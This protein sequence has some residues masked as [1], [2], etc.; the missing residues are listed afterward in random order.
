[1][2]I[3]SVQFKSTLGFAVC[4]FCLLLLVSG[5]RHA[6]PKMFDPAQVA[7]SASYAPL[8]ENQFYPSLIM[9]VA[10]LSDPAYALADSSA[11][12][13]VSVT[14]PVSNAVLRVT[15][16]SSKLN[17]VTIFQ[18]VLPVKDMRYTF[19]P[20][21]KWKF[22][23]LYRTRQQGVADL[24]FTCYINDEEVDVKNLRINYRSAND[25]L[26]S[27]RDSAGHGHDYRWLFAAYVNE[28]HPYI[29]SI[30][31]DIMQQGVVTKISGYQSDAKS[32]V[33]QAEAIWYYALERGI[34]Y[35]SISCTSTPTTRSN[36]QHI[37][38]FDEV[39]N[40]RQANCVDA[41]VFF[42]SIM[43]KIGLKPVIFVEPCHA[44][45]GFYTDKGRKNLRLL[46]TTI[47][48]WADFPALTRDYNAVMEA[49]P[50]AKGKARISAAMY[51][52]YGKYLT[53]N[54]KKNWEE[55]KTDFDSFKRAVAHNLFLKAMEY[56]QD[57]Y[58]NNKKLFADPDNT[59]YQ[60]LDIEQLRKIVQ[61]I[62]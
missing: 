44:Y 3:R 49:N 2:S 21:V 56:D 60:Q 52:K 20:T 8:F 4:G 13:S 35:S 32:V 54:E 10:S 18:E 25:C 51:T 37:R 45:L 15:I 24:T 23:Q 41:C 22:D 39:Y 46:E 57:N 43:R 11:L 29:D 42:A 6:R 5:C 17:Y 9:G 16:D 55:D 47:T 19:Y 27:V 30:L 38:F 14:A 61:P 36:V 50:E 34:R 33:A 26:L 48:A 28:E 7:F 58:K 53:A 1:M 62:N 12:F 40:S 31:T 59:Q